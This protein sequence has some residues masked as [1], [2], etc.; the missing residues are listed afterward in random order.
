[1]STCVHL[2][3]WPL[4]KDTQLQYG[5]DYWTLHSCHHPNMNKSLASG[6][7]HGFS[8]NQPV[9]AHL[10]AAN[11]PKSP[12]KPVDGM[13]VANKPAPTKH[14]TPSLTGLYI[15]NMCHENSLNHV[16]DRLGATGLDQHYPL[17]TCGVSQDVGDLNGRSSCKIPWQNPNVWTCSETCSILASPFHGKP[18][19][20][21]EW[22][23]L[24]IWCLY[25]AYYLLSWPGNS[26]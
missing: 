8:A 22:Y 4:I 19:M 13:F 17:D 18:Y 11:G 6:L 7:A 10:P 5:T 3:A 25:A 9:W 2:L 20:D 26:I 24:P 23:L 15:L 16:L 14:F 21:V 1:M 12:S